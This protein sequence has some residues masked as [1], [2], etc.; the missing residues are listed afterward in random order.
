MYI[1]RLV[2]DSLKSLA[3]APVGRCLILTG[4]RQTGKTTLLQREF[5]PEYEYHSFDEV[6]TRQDLAR[7]SASEWL[8]RDRN[9]IFD[10]VHKAPGFMG[11]VKVILDRGKGRN[12]VIL[13]GSAQIQLLSAFRG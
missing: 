1:S 9:Y 4:A 11:T 5:M 3:E 12:R 2:T 6:L 13:S 10:E 7:R 8:A